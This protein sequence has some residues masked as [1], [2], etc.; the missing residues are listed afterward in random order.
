M[1]T[2]KSKE[3][4]MLEWKKQ[5]DHWVAD[6]GAPKEG[7][8]EVRRK[9]IYISDKD[10]FVDGWKCSMIRLCTD[11]RMGLA[12]MI[13]ALTFEQAK[14]IAERHWETG[15]WFDADVARR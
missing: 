11:D 3:A 9:Q 8:Y 13:E 14:Q 7:W 5:D 6:G 10:E 2:G 4:D 15:A 1:N 12:A